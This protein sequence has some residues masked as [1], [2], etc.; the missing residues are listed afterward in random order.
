MMQIEE[1]NSSS[2]L[3]VKEIKQEYNIADLNNIITQLL[4]K[5]DPKLLKTFDFYSLKNNRG[6][7]LD[8]FNNLENIIKDKNLISDNLN[9]I[10]KI[11]ETIK[12][13]FQLLEEIKIDKPENNEIFTVF[14]ATTLSYL[15]KYFS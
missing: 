11:F 2:I 12:I 9:N 4:A 6:L 8:L 7:V 10:T 13:Q 1:K 14:L 5:I 3:P 15:K